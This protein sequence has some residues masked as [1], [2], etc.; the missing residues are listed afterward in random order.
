MFGIAHQATAQT[1]SAQFA[2]KNAGVRVEGSFKHV[3]TTIVY[4]KINPSNSR[5]SGEI[6]TT[7]ISTGIVMR[8]NHLRKSDFFDA[9]KYPTIKFVSTSVTASSANVLKVTG[10]LT[11]KDVTQNVTII[12]KVSEQGGKTTFSG[13]ATLNR[14]TYNVGGSS[15]I[16]SD[17]V[18]LEIKAVQ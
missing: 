4:D 10:N 2:I 9:S 3:S 15:W 14:M 16:M 17:E 7:S 13:T 5:F 6:K 18:T 1:A 12:V 11:I 8:D